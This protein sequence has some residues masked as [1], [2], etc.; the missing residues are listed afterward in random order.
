MAVLVQSLAYL[1]RA[2]QR[3][4]QPWQLILSLGCADKPVDS[5][6]ASDLGLQLLHVDS[7]RS[8][9]VA[10]TAMALILALLRRTPALAAQAGASAGWL[11]ALPAACRGMRRCRGQVLGIIGATASAC[12]LAIRCLAFKMNVMY[13]DTE[14]VRKQLFVWPS[15]DIYYIIATVAYV[16]ECRS[17]L[18]GRVISGHT[19]HTLNHSMSHSVFTNRMKD[20]YS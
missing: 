18:C 6:L 5:G 13:L 2:A 15:L 11:G 16:M 14:E 20:K 3:R 8:E 1:P 19:K 7:G 12:A 9:E 4:L 17:R 10:D